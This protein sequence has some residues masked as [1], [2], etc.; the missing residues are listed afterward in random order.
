MFR[1]KHRSADI[2]LRMLWRYIPCNTNLNFCLYRYILSD[3]MHTLV[4]VTIVFRFRKRYPYLIRDA[5]R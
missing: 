4:N 2:Y 5:Q 1:K 3:V